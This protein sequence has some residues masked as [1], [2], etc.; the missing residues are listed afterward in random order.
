MDDKSKELNALEGKWKSLSNIKADNHSILSEKL[1]T[2]ENLLEFFDE[3]LG[4]RDIHLTEDDL[5]F[6]REAAMF[7][8]LYASKVVL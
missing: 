5:M 4:S 7:H 6:Q 2:A 3:N 8:F 1:L